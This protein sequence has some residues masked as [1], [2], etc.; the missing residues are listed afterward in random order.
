MFGKDKHFFDICNKYVFF[1]GRLLQITPVL[2][3][4]SN[5]VKPPKWC[6]WGD[7]LRQQVF[8]VVKMRGFGGT[9]KRIIFTMSPGLLAGVLHFPPQGKCTHSLTHSLKALSPLRV[10]H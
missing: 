9:P 7:F 1:G 4:G 10:G 8:H 3:N 5:A 2:L 6:G